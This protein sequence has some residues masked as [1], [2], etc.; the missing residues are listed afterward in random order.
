MLCQLLLGRRKTWEKPDP[1]SQGHAP[2]RG[3]IDEG[4]RH[5]PSL[6]LH[7]SRSAE[8]KGQGLLSGQHRVC[9]LEVRVHGT[10]QVEEHNRKTVRNNAGH[11]MCPALSLTDST[12][13]ATGRG[14]TSLRPC[15]SSE[16]GK[17]RSAHPRYTKVHG[18]RN[19]GNRESRRR[20][21]RR[22]SSGSTQSRS[23]AKSPEP[24]A[25]G[26]PEAVRQRVSCDPGSSIDASHWRHRRGSASSM[27]RASASAG[28]TGRWPTWW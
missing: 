8:Q 5:L 14:R 12:C 13:W 1:S 11:V 25:G 2:R 20:R 28:N 7:E 24:R 21:R 10:K 19:V 18:R 9:R 16:N 22:W 17:A 4:L 15:S 3:Y 6:L 27:P 26:S 23:T